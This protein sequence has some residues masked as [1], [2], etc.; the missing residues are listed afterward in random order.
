MDPEPTYTKASADRLLPLLSRILEE[1]REQL[2]LAADP[3][4]ARRLG[5][6]AAHNGG[7]EWA[8]QALAAGEGAQRNVQFLSARGILLR[9]AGSGLVDFPSVVD[10]TA[11]YLCWQ[12]GE[13][14]VAFWHPRDLGYSARR[15]LSP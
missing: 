9:D 10:G 5:R 2:G 4:T 13:D 3:L 12:L 7:G 11:A 1:L 14:E 6:A 15:P 8:N